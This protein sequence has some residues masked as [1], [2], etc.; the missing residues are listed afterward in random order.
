[1]MRVRVSEILLAFVLSGAVGCSSMDPADRGGP[2]LVVGLTG[3]Y[4]PLNYTDESG[5]LT[6]F[7]V[8][9][10]NEVCKE[11][12]RPCEFRT[13]Q[14]DGI[15]GALLAGRID[16]VIGSMA[17]TE[18][19]SREV[20]FSHPY[21]E[22]GA[23]LFV[24]RGRPAADR[25]HLTIGVTLGTT[26]EEHVRT[27][28][29]HAELRTYKGDTEVLTDMAAGRLD[30]MVTDRLVGAYMARKFGVDLIPE[31]E[32]LYEEKIA[33]PVAPDQHALLGEIDSAVDRIRASERYDRMLAKYF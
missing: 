10:A 2:P 33:I 22:S 5:E 19:R 9:F 30:A 23:Q 17:V 6:G 26:Y 1:M 7:D 12:R 28:Y 16:V 27:R 8:D 18:A 13:L 4:P 21:Y 3:K 14:W 15:I 31:G 11:L 29:P 32:L 25:A 24:P 20:R